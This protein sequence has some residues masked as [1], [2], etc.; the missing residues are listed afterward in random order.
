MGRLVPFFRVENTLTFWF[1]FPFPENVVQ[2]WVVDFNYPNPIL[3]KNSTIFKPTH[4]Q[5]LGLLQFL[6]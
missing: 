5:A 2:I 4:F 1:S 6:K 3:K